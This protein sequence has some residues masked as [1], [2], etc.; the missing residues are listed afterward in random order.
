MYQPPREN[1]WLEG[2]ELQDSAFPYHDWNERVAAESYVPNSAARILDGEGRV[3]DIVSNYARVSF[4]FGPTLLSWME[5]HAAEAYDSII[6]ADRVSRE[7]RSGHGNAIA[8]VYNHVIMPLANTR[9][10][11]TQ[12]VW[13]IRDFRHRFQRKPEGMWLAE[14][15]VDLETLEILAEHE[16]AFTILA[17]RQAA[18]VRKLGTGKWR[19]VSGARIDPA[20]AYLCRLPSGRRI[21]LFFY[22]GPIS[23]AVAFEG[24]LE[25]GEDFANRLLTG[26]SEARDWAQLMHVATDGE[27][28]GHHH[29]FGE[30]ALAYALTHIESFGLATLTNYGEYLEKHPPTH[31]VQIY[32]NSSWS[33][34]HGV[35]RW[36]SDC[37]CN[38]GG[39]RQWNQQWRAPLRDALDGLRDE[40]AQMFEQKSA[41]YLKDPWAARDDYIWVILDR[42]EETI[43]CVL[44]RHATRA[45]S[46][47]EKG[48]VLRLMEMQRQAMLMYTSCGWF[49]DE[50]SGIETVQILQY[51]GRAL[52]LAEEFGPAGLE[53]KFKER[54][55][56]AQSNIDDQGNG[57]DIYERYVKQAVIDLK[58]VAAHYAV[59]SLFEDYGD[60]S[61]IYSYEITREDYT[62]SLAGL[63]KLA[64]G[65]VRVVSS[66]TRIA[67]TVSFCVL[68]FGGHSLNGGVRTF[69]GEEAYHAM[70]TEVETA[71]EKGDFTG[72]VRLMDVHFGM[73]N[74]S[75]L[76][77]FKD[78]QR[79]ILRILTDSVIDEFV[80]RYRDIYERNRIMMGFL[81]TT[82]MPVPRAFLN[83][84]EYVLNYDLWNALHEEP[85]NIA[86]AREILSEITR[87]GADVDAVRIEFF[88]RHK[89]EAVMGQFMREPSNLELLL[90]I[91]R[92][93]EFLGTL[94]GEVNLWEIQNMFFALVRTAYEEFRR[95][96]EA[97]DPAAVRWVESFRDLGVALAFNIKAVLG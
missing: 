77:L 33:C 86:G 58:K 26:F 80:E 2:I 21:T 91:R 31:E 14:A 38:S 78:E 13:G 28:Y 94:P 27:S 35:E 89:L 8:Q 62:R 84:A 54:L 10:K 42:S 3:M 76:D 45:L 53:P 5:A 67:E 96:S 52:Q 44:G 16:I 73:H 59:S 61:R 15:A 41:A 64:I 25:R 83:A 75:L 32:E 82:G 7:K 47:E 57:A 48:T 12:I 40:L 51:A 18:R 24:L 37:G 93:T 85:I 65:R 17:P 39:N 4:N 69:L 46:E 88:V 30:M 60:V 49:F 56:M 63:V 55:S 71:F 36:R 68:H 20:R 6:D 81:R 87:W 90:E 74:Y 11:R 43:D 23:S 9:D 50:L 79:N 1:P 34:I 97:G 92:V 22:D 19:D 29:R 95:K 70:K 66:L 72:I